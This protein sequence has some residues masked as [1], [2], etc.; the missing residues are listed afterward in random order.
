MRMMSLEEEEFER[1]LD[2][3]Q[4]Y[5]D[6]RISDQIKIEKLKPMSKVA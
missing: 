6:R 3:N 2:S 5:E 1:D 4:V